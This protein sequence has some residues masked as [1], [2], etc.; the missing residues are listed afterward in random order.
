[1]AQL[2]FSDLFNGFHGFSIRKI[3]IFVRTFGDAHWLLKTIVRAGLRDDFTDDLRDDFSHDFNVDLS[4]DHASCNDFLS[5]LTVRF[6]PHVLLRAM[7]E[8]RFI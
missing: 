5:Q 8:E 3:K 6:L 2:Q 4:A 7:M 1:V